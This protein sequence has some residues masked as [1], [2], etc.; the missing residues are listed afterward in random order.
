MSGYNAGYNNELFLGC[1]L[2]AYLCGLILFLFFQKVGK[3]LGKKFGRKKMRGGVVW[4]GEGGGSIK[5][6]TMSYLS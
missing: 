4:G 2:Y 5:Q 3:K 1:I 6:D